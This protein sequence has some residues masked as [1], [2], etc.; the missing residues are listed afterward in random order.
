MGMNR[1]AGARASDRG[2]DKA[3]DRIAAMFDAISSRY[4]LLNRVLS[5]GFDRRWR[6]RAVSALAFTGRET[7]L[8]LC[9][10]TGDVAIAAVVSRRPPARVI[11]LDFAGRMLA[12]ARQKV[13][14]GPTRRRVHLAQADAACLPMPDASV[15]AVTVAFGIRNVQQLPR[16]FAEMHRVLKPGG[17]LAIL[18]FGTPRLRGVRALYLWYFHRLLPRIGQLISGHDS[19]Y[20]YLPASVGRFPPPEELASLMTREGFRD[21]RFV[22]L[23]L[24]IVY[25]YEASKSSR[26]GTML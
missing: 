11:G 21:A 4:D 16:A 22:S 3:P 12:L 18:E 14:G 23:T 26:A 20:A 19:A 5:F 24:G 6:D 10:G 2:V 7:L 9:T 17:R 8:D 15:D 13:G 1:D 25:L